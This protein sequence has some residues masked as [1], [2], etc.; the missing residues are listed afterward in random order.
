MKKFNLI[1]CLLLTVVACQEKMPDLKDSEV[2]LDEGG[3]KTLENVKHPTIDMTEALSIIKP[4]TDQYPGRWVDISKDII[5]A[6]TSID[7]APLGI[8]ALQREG[9]VV[10]S[11]NYDSWLAVVEYDVC[12]MED[13]RRFCISLSILIQESILRCGLMA[14]PLL[15]GIHQG[16]YTRSPKLIMLCLKAVLFQEFRLEPVPVAHLLPDGQ[17]F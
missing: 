14:R 6:G 4:E 5:P 1:V 10:K 17:C 11:P 8:K 12:K 7:Y 3:G 9:A 2:L 15:N 16:I 13:M